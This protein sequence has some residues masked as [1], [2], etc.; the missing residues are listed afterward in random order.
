MSNLNNLVSVCFED[1]KRDDEVVIQDY[2][3]NA[4]GARGKIYHLDV[5]TKMISVVTNGMVDTWEGLAD[6][7]LKI[8]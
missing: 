1:L 2:G 3:H 8:V 5:D 7:I 6:G 4:Y